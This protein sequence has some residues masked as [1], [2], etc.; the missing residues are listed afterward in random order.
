[1]G[2]MEE[3]LRGMEYRVIRS[4]IHLIEMIFSMC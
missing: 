1:M 4:A 2:K 3:R